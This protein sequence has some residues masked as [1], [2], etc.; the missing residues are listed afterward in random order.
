MDNAPVNLS[1][2]TEN[3]DQTK[4][5]ADSDVVDIPLE[6]KNDLHTEFFTF[7]FFF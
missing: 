7:M 6:S 1:G 4:M 5:S 3:V 2:D